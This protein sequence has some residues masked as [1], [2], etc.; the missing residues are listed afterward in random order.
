MIGCE[1]FRPISSTESAEF[2]PA[3]N[4]VSVLDQSSMPTVQFQLQV[5]K[6]IGGNPLR[7]VQLPNLQH[8]SHTVTSHSNLLHGLHFHHS[9]KGSKVSKV[10]AAL[11]AFDK[12]YSIDWSTSRALCW[13]IRYQ[14]TH[15]KSTLLTCKR[16]MPH[17]LAS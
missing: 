11:C 17:L 6:A 16:K 14:Q 2:A 1:T 9:R 12:L 8:F 7:L 10:C 13:T 5:S 3:K 15:P 4:K